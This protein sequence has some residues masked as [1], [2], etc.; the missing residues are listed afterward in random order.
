MLEF[1]VDNVLK[2]VF[3][4]SLLVLEILGF[5][6]LQKSPPS[7]DFGEIFVRLYSLGEVLAL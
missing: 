2:L 4:I 6:E 3:F 1:L 5:K 7:P